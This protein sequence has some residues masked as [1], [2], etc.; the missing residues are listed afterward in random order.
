MG[1]TDDSDSGKPIEPLHGP[2]LTMHGVPVCAQPELRAALG[3]LEKPDVG[4]A[5]AKQAY[6]PMGDTDPN[7]PGVTV[8][9]LEGDGF[10]ELLLANLDVQLFEV[11]PT[12]WTEIG[13]ERFPEHGD[14]FARAISPALS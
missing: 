11:G 7:G 14:L 1:A 9:D 6:E 10:P 5:W 8:A 3:P 2:G 13:A 12:G 4:A